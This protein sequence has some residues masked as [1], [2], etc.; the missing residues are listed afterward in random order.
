MSNPTG[1]KTVPAIPAHIERLTV[2]QADAFY[3]ARV[4]SVEA[5]AVINRA[6][7]SAW[8]YYDGI[9]TDTHRLF[10]ARVYARI[11]ADIAT[12]EDQ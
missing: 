8:N 3:D 9:F 10:D 4:S 2:E 1:E 6:A 7:R 5:F 11:S 12:W